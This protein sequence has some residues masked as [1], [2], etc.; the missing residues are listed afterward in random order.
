MCP[1][2]IGD[3]RELVAEKY[4]LPVSSWDP[5]D[6]GSCLARLIGMR[7]LCFATVCLLPCSHIAQMRAE[8][9]FRRHGATTVCPCCCCWCG[10]GSGPGG[11]ASDDGELDYPRDKEAERP[12]ETKPIKKE[13]LDY[14]RVGEETYDLTPPEPKPEVVADYPRMG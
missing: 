7:L 13:P 4:N 5:D 9:A 3:T 12:K 2:W 1:C 10:G 14:P 8:V 6:C 11:D